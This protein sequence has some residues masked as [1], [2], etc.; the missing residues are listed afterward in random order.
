M[1][2]GVMHVACLCVGCHLMFLFHP[3]LML[4]RRG[5]KLTGSNI[6]EDEQI[7]QLQFDFDGKR[8]RWN[9]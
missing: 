6:A 4:C 7:S 3:N 1:Y 9:G 5:A 2:D 8:D